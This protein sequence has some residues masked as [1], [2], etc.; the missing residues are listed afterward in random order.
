[1]NEICGSLFLGKRPFKDLNYL[2]QISRSE[3]EP[4]MQLSKSYMTPIFVT[5]GHI[6]V[7][8]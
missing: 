2:K 5:V 8:I 3:K 4:E 1:M 6:G 7:L